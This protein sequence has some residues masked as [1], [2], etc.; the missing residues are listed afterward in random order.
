MP[1]RFVKDYHVLYYVSQ[2][3]KPTTAFIF[4]FLSEWKCDETLG[5]SVQL[6]QMLHDVF[7]LNRL[8]GEQKK[9]KKKEQKTFKD[10]LPE[11]C[12]CNANTLS[13]N[14]AFANRDIFSQKMF[15]NFY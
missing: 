14:S 13:K 5:N 4:M 2:R 15:L 12:M 7:T 8:F 10:F 6:C 3:W 1:C 9:S 11:S